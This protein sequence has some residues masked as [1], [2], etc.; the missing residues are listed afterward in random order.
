MNFV[1]L[2][3]EAN[4]RRTSTMKKH[5]PVSLVL[6][7][8]SVSLQWKHYY[9]HKTGN[10]YTWCIKTL[11]TGNDS[12]FVW[13]RWYYSYNCNGMMMMMKFYLSRVNFT[14]WKDS[15]CHSADCSLP[16]IQKWTKVSTTFITF[17]L[18][19]MSTTSMFPH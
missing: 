4:S 3:C 18:I 8:F 1:Y 13:F 15:F 2:H 14:L 5:R 11:N 12:Q 7:E 19:R 10:L 16:S 6:Q 17:L 9:L